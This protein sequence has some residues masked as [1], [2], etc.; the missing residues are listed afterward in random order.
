MEEVG[1]GQL[2]DEIDIIIWMGQ[3]S[4]WQIKKGIVEEGLRRSD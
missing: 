1:K 4:G 3:E 2:G